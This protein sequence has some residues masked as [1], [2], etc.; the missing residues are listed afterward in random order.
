L[1]FIANLI[2][3]GVRFVAV[4]MLHATK[5]TVHTMAAVAEQEAEAHFQ[6]SKRIKAALEAARGAS[7]HSIS[8]LAAITRIQPPYMPSVTFTGNRSVHPGTEVG[9]QKMTG[10]AK[11]GSCGWSQAR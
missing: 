5:F 8:G 6:A 11:D 4:D 7:L 9:L 3:S 2:E 1:A 10:A